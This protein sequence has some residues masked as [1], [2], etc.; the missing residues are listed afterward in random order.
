MPAQNTLFAP[1]Q[2]ET[3]SFPTFPS[4]NVVRIAKT[5]LLPR[6]DDFGNLGVGA[7]TSVGT[8]HTRADSPSMPGK[9]H[10]Y[11]AKSTKRSLF[12]GGPDDR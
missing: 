7:E 6:T 10:C 3:N 2:D 9:Q 11:G 5:I 4:E 1:T 8:V 12:V